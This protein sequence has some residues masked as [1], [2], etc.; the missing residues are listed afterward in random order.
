MSLFKLI[1]R[2][3][4][5]TAHLAILLCLLAKPA[6]GEENELPRSSLTEAIASGDALK[7]ELHQTLR[8]LK[9]PQTINSAVVSPDTELLD[10][11]TGQLLRWKAELEAALL[12]TSASDDTALDAERKAYLINLY[13]GLLASLIQAQHIIASRFDWRTAGEQFTLTVPLELTWSR[14]QTLARLFTQQVQVKQA[15]DESQARLQ[16]K[17]AFVDGLQ[18]ATRALYADRTNHL[19]A[20]KYL[21][22]AMLYRQ[23]VQNEHY[24]G[25]RTERLPDL[26]SKDDRGYD[27]GLRESI[28]AD[29]RRTRA[30]QFLYAALLEAL[31]RLP[32]PEAGLQQPLIANWHLYEQ[33]H[34]A[35]P[36]MSVF[37]TPL[38]AQQLYAL[39]DDEQLKAVAVNDDEEMRRFMLLAEQLYLPLVLEKDLP[40]LTLPLDGSAAAARALQQA[41]VQ[42]RFS[43]LLNAL[44][45][46]RLRRDKIKPLLASLQE[47]QK[48][49]LALTSTQEVTRW[50]EAARQLVPVVKQRMRQALMRE[51]L[52]AA[53]KVDTAEHADDE[54]LNLPILRRAL[55][56]S[57]YVTD[58]SGEFQQSLA[59]VLQARGYAQSR[60][61][62]F[63]QLAR[64]LQ[65]LVPQRPPSAQDLRFIS[66]DD[67]VRTY[68]NPAL[69]T[70]RTLE[71]DAAHAVQRKTLL[72][73]ITQIKALLQH[74][75]WLG[76]FTHKGDSVPRL[77]D[78]PLNAQQRA[79][80][81]RELRFARF[82]QY[83]FML[84]PIKASKDKPL[85]ATGIRAESYVEKQQ[86][87]YKILAAKLRA[88]DLRDIDNEA[89]AGFWPLIAEALDAQRQRII[90]ALQKI[91]TADTLQ[92]IKHLAANSRAVAAGMKEFAV[93]YPHYKEFA[94]RYHQPSKLQHS[95]ERIDLTYIGNFFTVIIGWHLGGWLLRK[96]VPTSYLLRY[97]NP[98][99]GAILPYTNT[100]MM[101]FWYVI[102]VDYFGIKVWQTFVSKPRKL[103][104][105]QE[106]YYLGNQHNQFVNRTYLDYLAMEKTAQIFNYGF[107]AAM[108]GLFVGWAAY[109]RLLPH[110]L[111]NI[112]NARLQRLFSRVGFRTADGKPLS[113]V[114]A[115]ASRHEIFNREKINQR[116]AAELAKVE[117]ARQAGRI[118]KSYA[119]QE[120]HQI[121]LARDK[122]FISMAKKERALRVAEIEHTYDFRALNLSQPVFHAEEI[123]KAHH[124]LAGALRGKQD[125][126]SHFALRDADTALVNIRESLMRRL[127]FQII[128]SRAEVREQIRYLSAEHREALE[129][130]NI[131]PNRNSTFSQ[132]QLQKA[133]AE[134]KRRF[135]K[136]AQRVDSNHSYFE[137]KNAYDSIYRAKEELDAF[138]IADGWHSAMFEAIIDRRF[139]HARLHSEAELTVLGKMV[140][141]LKIDLADRKI[142]TANV[143]ESK[144]NVEIKLNTG[145]QEAVKSRYNE[146][147]ATYRNRLSGAELQEKLQE[148]RAARDTL[149]RGE[150]NSAIQGLLRRAH[151]ENFYR[152]LKLE[153]KQAEAYTEKEISKAYKKMM[154]H[155]DP[156]K[157]AGK[158][159][160]EIEAM[161]DMFKAVTEAGKGL[162]NPHIKS[163][164]DAYLHQYLHGSGS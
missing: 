67:I 163:K 12:S 35:S 25:T 91:D 115:F 68:V 108:L 114:D 128:R 126:F 47:R 49:L 129:R 73:H 36:D 145:W 124:D 109:Q 116:V 149:L 113:E 146:T 86:P 161:E 38:L 88:R 4:K 55:L 99:F 62:F 59:A 28:I 84:L 79:D 14:S 54:P 44:A 92:D 152:L 112:K 151:Y 51:V 156:L 164:I 135:P 50:Y 10:S 85:P 83:P 94:H 118:S 147:E 65:R 148:L 7:V 41:L 76:Y 53:W 21:T 63:H 101:A 122:I 87:L 31:P 56:R 89:I 80:Y 16:L 141:L 81:W 97:L 13:F 104:E 154:S 105:L 117:E 39:L 1:S 6:A 72:Q 131:A 34:A 144:L 77:D 70:A 9:Y 46:L 138:R 64:H 136:E 11:M 134:I 95:W 139:G 106:Y 43:A 71:S 23:L 150:N 24:R 98:A 133:E 110:L 119:R 33:L 74:G 159:E 37:T 27:L 8:S 15:A 18:I 82:D 5:T 125:L 3:S 40:R 96:S 32:A 153:P 90:T 20:V 155:Y 48:T 22:Y 103:G 121:E 143:D 158:S 30:D 78:L 17:P 58:F 69:A 160:Q 52:Y 137:W 93:L 102:L 132:R 66:Q 29:Q 107:E 130:F 162:R 75:Y 60:M 111:P 140:E 142:S 123:Y 61:V 120:K 100:L 19:A 57:M 26:P 2:K 45:P 42:A 157:R 127:K